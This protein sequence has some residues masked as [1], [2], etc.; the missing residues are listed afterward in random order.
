MEQHDVNVYIHPRLTC[1]PCLMGRADIY[2][3]Y[4]FTSATTMEYVWN[5]VDVVKLY[6]EK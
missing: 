1:F 6:N 5:N 2:Y 4:V 3:M